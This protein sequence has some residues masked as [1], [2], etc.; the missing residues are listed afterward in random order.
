MN[1]KRHLPS[2]FGIVSIILLV[3]SVLPVHATVVVFDSYA[4]SNRD[5]DDTF[6]TAPIG[7]G[8][9]FTASTTAF[10]TQSKFALKD[11]DGITGIGKSRI[12]AT[13]GT[14]GSSCKP[15]GAPL[16]TSDD[17]P[18]SAVTTGYQFLAFSFS[19]GNN[20]QLVSG[21][22]YAISF[23]WDSG[24]TGASPLLIG[25]D[26]SSSSH[27]GNKFE[28][29]TN[30]ASPSCATNATVD[31]VFEVG[32]DTAIAGGTI[33]TQCYGNCDTVV[34]TN[35][36]KSINFNVSQTI[37]YKQQ[38][39]QD[40]FAIN[41]S[42]VVGKSYIASFGLTL[43]LGLYATDLSCPSLASAFTP[44]CPAFLLRSEAFVNP[45]K[46][47]VTMALNNQL[48]AGQTVGI[49]F[50]AN[51]DGLVLNDTTTIQASFKT[52]GIMPTV[53]TQFESN[54]NLKTNLKLT[55]EIVV[56]TPT[57]PSTT[58]ALGDWLLSLI[59][60]FGGGRIAGG[61]FWFFAFSLGII[62]GLVKF[63]DDRDVDMQLG[64]VAPFIFLGTASLFS[65]LGALP[66][67]IPILIFVIVA[68]M[69]STKITER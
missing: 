6:G 32:G 67:W 43:F 40:G 19:G 52:S 48:K 50:S 1:V 57:G 58:P 31:L 24:T 16:A 14:F 3:V 65:S 69:F 54:G 63:A 2:I 20:I 42:S 62:I 17:F 15:S 4:F 56:P 28:S 41:M 10:L 37:F 38:I 30:S 61:I 34:N 53:I 47:T 60:N 44:S 18:M 68:W 12:Y 66:A 13:T 7:W 5:G 11:S 45:Q 22:I 49:A 21:T 33:I 51:R 23:W 36:T 25:T 59:D 55:I 27:N 46:G 39:Q 9:C 64:T 35:S 8:Q 29:C 26:I